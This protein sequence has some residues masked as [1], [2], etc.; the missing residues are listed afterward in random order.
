MLLHNQFQSHCMQ[1]VGSKAEIRDI[2]V[3]LALASAAADARNKQLLL[4]HGDKQEKS[5][6][7]N[8]VSKYEMR[9]SLRCCGA[10]Y[11]LCSLTSKVLPCGV[12]D[13]YNAAIAYRRA[14]DSRSRQFYANIYDF[15]LFMAEREEE[16]DE[17]ATFKD[18]KGKNGKHSRQTNATAAAAATED[19]EDDATED[20][21]DGGDNADTG[22]TWRTAFE[23]MIEDAA[24]YGTDMCGAIMEEFVTDQCKENAQV[25]MGIL[26][27][28][29]DSRQHMC[30]LS[31]IDS[32]R[33]CRPC[34]SIQWT[35]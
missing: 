3:T 30:A 1:N 4:W 22:A 25:S 17:T 15:A 18:T 27:G 19:R 5:L 23:A 9:R 34:Y 21:P 10:C 12:K 8:A 6:A 11:V 29:P 35:G 2:Q 24:C 33:T 14:E 28:V 20:D 7:R 32:Y 16:G 26:A 31:T 13:M